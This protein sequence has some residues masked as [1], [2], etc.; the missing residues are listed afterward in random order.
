MATDHCP[1]CI[2]K[3]GQAK[4]LYASEE[5]AFD[6]ANHRNSESGIML[7]VYPCPYNAGWHLTSN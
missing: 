4:N 5:E 2:G 3:N 1:Y 6:V 7:R